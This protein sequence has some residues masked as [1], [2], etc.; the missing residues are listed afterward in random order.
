MGPM[1]G[2]LLQKLIIK[3]TP[4]QKDQDHLQVICF[5][6]PQ[7]PDRT[8]SLKNAG[9]RQFV[10]AIQKSGEILANAGST[11]LVI[12]CNTAHARFEEIQ[13]AI[14]VPILNIVEAAVDYIVKTYGAQRAVGLLATDGTLAERIY[15]K[16]IKEPVLRYITPPPADQKELMR[17]IYE[18]KIGHGDLVGGELAGISKRLIA[19]GAGAILLGCTELSLYFEELKKCGKPVVDPLR[20]AA[21]ALVRKNL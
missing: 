12:P 10:S 13:K 4:A 8:E 3:A 9:G 15:Q 21:H 17:I 6:N 5:T 19:A 1:A 20:I 7:V 2:V 16:A 11:V 14:P 18:I